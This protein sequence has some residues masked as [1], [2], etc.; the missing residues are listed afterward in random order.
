MCGRYT[1]V[2]DLASVCERFGVRPLPFDPGPRYNIAPTQGVPI[3]INDGG[4]RELLL[5]QWGLVPF[6]ARDP[7]IGS[8]LINARAETLAEKASFK[9]ALARRRCLIPA[10]GFYEWLRTGGSTQPYYIRRTDQALFAFA[11]LW[12]EWGSPDGSPL[13]SCA[14]ITVEPNAL[15]APIHNRMPAI[16]SEEQEEPWMAGVSARPRSTARTE[17]PEERWRGMLRP[18]PGD[19]LEAY[20]VSRAVNNPRYTGQDCIDP[21][22]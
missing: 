7:E 5:A 16:L 8:R 6:W 21:A 2:H 19:D 13:I 11:G 15:L 3:I 20:A 14:I 18:W 1:I 4:R 12:E 17:P 22:P 10:D 9:H